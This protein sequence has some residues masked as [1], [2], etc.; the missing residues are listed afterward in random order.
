MK[1][2]F[3]TLALTAFLS[4]STHAQFCAQQG[5][6]V[7][8]RGENGAVMSESELTA[9][10][11]Q[12]SP[13]LGES[14]VRMA[15]ARLDIAEDSRYQISGVRPPS[16]IALLYFHGTV[17][18]CALHLNEVTLVRRQQRMRLVFNVT[19]PFAEIT[20]DMRKSPPAVIVDSP[21]FEN[22]EFELRLEPWLAGL[23]RAS[24]GEAPFPVIGSENWTRTQ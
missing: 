12:S 14:G 20:H 17:T 18:N 3:A 7:I 10:Q 9:I 13:S 4:F 8:V 11:T 19:M 1:P 21:S 24:T 23:E 22:G 15:V 16:S 2:A 6:Y 5:I